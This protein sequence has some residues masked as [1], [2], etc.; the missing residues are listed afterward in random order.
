MIMVTKKD[1]I[2]AVSTRRGLPSGVRG[3]KE[4]ENDSGWVGQKPQ[5]ALDAQDIEPHGQ[6]G[7]GPQAD[8]DGQRE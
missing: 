2:H 3:H 1:R 5:P 4:S 7:R 8:G 6:E